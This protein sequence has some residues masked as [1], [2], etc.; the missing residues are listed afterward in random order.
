M[1][2]TLIDGK[3][4]SREIRGNIQMAV[5]NRLDSHLSRP[6]LAVI[7]IGQNPASAIYVEHKRKACEEVGITSFAYNLPESTPESRLLA[8]ISELNLKPE[9]HGILVQLP[10]P[11]H[12]DSTLVIEAIAP[13]KDVDGFHPYNL[14]RLAQRTPV[15]RPCTPYGIME[16]LKFHKAPVRGMQACVVG[17]SNIVGRPMTLELLLA[18]ATVTSCHRFT[19]NLKSHVENADLLVVAVGKPNLIP[20]NWIKPGSWVIDV[21]MNRL[22]NGKLVGDV[23][24]EVAKTRAAYI[25]PV[26]GG[27]GPMTVTMLLH[28]TLHAAHLFDSTVEKKEAR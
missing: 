22:E 19:Q 24:F 13:K 7:M 17:A 15:L 27:V 28:N 21:G 1:T 9:I 26:P 3:H 25:T 4:I 10:L 8:L 16:M 2:A 14:G 11:Q 23:E 20:G 5:Q 18:A 6:G 12:I